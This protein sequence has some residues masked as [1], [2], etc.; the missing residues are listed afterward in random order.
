MRQCCCK[1][2]VAPASP[3]FPLPCCTLVSP[4]LICEMDLCCL[5][6]CATDMDTWK[7]RRRAIVPGELPL[8]LTASL[9]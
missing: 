2:G 6:P 3:L 1:G 9:V 8:G 5:L 7:V 4:G